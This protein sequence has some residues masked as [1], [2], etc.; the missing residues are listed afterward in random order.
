MAEFPLVNARLETGHPDFDIN[1]KINNIVTA[2]ND[3]DILS[4]H[5]FGTISTPPIIPTLPL[6]APWDIL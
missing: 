6:R 3:C 2:Y 4:D 1:P 5:R